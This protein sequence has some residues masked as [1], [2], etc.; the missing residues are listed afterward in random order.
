MTPGPSGAARIV[1]AAQIGGVRL[2]EASARTVL[3]SVR[4]IEGE[5]QLFVG[6]GATVKGPPDDKGEFY[7]LA[8]VDARVAPAPKAEPL[9]SI[10]AAF[11]LRYRLPEG[12]TATMEELEAFA[13][14]NG[15]FNA[16][17]YWREFVQSTSVRMDLPPVVLPLFRVHRG[18]EDELVEPKHRV[19]EKGTKRMAAGKGRR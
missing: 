1:A 6:T 14:V 2:V 11:E 5:A 9:I 4:D 16:W 18:P 7:V 19:R 12:Q 8:K 15:V 17:P 13:E 3:R 10:R